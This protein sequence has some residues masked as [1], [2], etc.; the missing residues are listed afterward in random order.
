MRIAALFISILALHACESKREDPP[1][2]SS[3]ALGGNM[4]GAKPRDMAN[5]PSAVPGARTTVEMIPDGVVV[6]VTSNDAAAQQEILK[7]VELQAQAAQVPPGAPHSGKHGGPARVGFCPSVHDDTT[8]DVEKVDG[9]A[10]MTVKP[11]SKRHVGELQ[12]ST[13]ARAARLPGFTSS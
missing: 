9:G 2:P 10:Q 3:P 7:R 8:I 1:R 11:V 4:S 13:K 6:T 12:A 5:C